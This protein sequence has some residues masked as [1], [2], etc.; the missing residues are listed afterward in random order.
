MVRNLENYTGL[1]TGLQQ[2][3]MVITQGYQNAS[4]DIREL[5]SGSLAR[6]TE[7]DRVFIQRASTALGEWTRAY[8]AAVG[9]HTNLPVFDLLQ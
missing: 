9:S 8:Q 4:E 2:L 7:R 1:L 5:V 3:V 6:A